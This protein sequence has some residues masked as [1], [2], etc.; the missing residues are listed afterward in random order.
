MQKFF[1]PVC[2]SKDEYDKDWYL[3]DDF[4]TFRTTYY[5]SGIDLNL[6]TG[7]DSDLGKPLYACL[8]GKIKYYHNASHP[9]L[10]YGRHMVLEVDTPN[11]KRWLHYA[12]CQSIT[13]ESKEVKVGDV[14]G[15]LGKSGTK[16]AHLHFSVF[17]VDPGGKGID[18][19]PNT[20][21]ELE[22]WQDPEEFFRELENYSEEETA[23]QKE[24]RLHE[25]TRNQLRGLRD[26][27]AIATET[28]KKRLKMIAKNMD[29][30]HLDSDIDNE[31]EKL[32]KKVVEESVNFGKYKKNSDDL[33]DFKQKTIDK[34]KKVYLQ[35]QEEL[36]V[37]RGEKERL[38]KLLRN[39]GVKIDTAI[40]GTV[41]AKENIEK[42][43]FT[44]KENPILAII[45]KVLS[46][47]K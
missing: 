34:E 20:K 46:I 41:E 13:A 27:V 7:G 21:D 36:R 19:I 38:E 43:D 14:I 44:P 10:G 35:H 2:Q 5:H 30:R 37:L 25:K 15:K 22:E 26:N 42:A 17:V 4:G 45:N 33:E 6:K 39:L 9:N 31:R 12:H 8:D 32:W 1:Y 28:E 40:E 47:F 16:Y 11:G 29:V 24:R 3:A 18:N 23:L